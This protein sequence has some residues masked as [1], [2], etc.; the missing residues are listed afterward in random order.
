MAAETERQAAMVAHLKDLP[1]FRS[2]TSAGARRALAERLFPQ[3]D[4]DDH[5][6]FRIREVVGEAHE[7]VQQAGKALYADYE[8]RLEELAD[9][10]LAS[11]LLERTQGARPRRIKN[12]DFLT[13]RSGGYLPPTWTLTLLLGHPKLKQRKTSSLARD[14]A[15][16]PLE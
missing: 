15:T 13:D 14:A 16:L 9:E 3:P 8:G 12:A 2:T 7:A 10:L 6:S 5:H 4:D 1:E 11:G